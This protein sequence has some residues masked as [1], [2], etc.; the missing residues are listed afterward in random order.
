[1]KFTPHKLL[2]VG[3]ALLLQTTAFAQEYHSNDVTPAG[4]GSGKLTAASA[5]RQVG[6]SQGVGSYN[7]HAVLLSGN[8]V[9]G[10]DLNPP[11]S[12]YSLATC[13]DDLQ[14]GGW[15][16]FA[17][18]QHAVVWSG[19]AASCAD[20]NPSGYNFSYCLGVHA[21]EQVGYAQLQSYFISASHAYSWHGSSASGVDLH[22][23]SAYSFSRAVACH[24]GEE[25]GCVSTIA[26]PE[27]EYSITYYHT[28]SHAMRWAGTAASAVDLHPL[29]FDSSEATCTSG[30]QQGG[31]GYIALGI[32]HLHAL[33]WSGTADTV[34]D[35][36]PN[37]YTESRISAMNATQQV[38]DGW[39][40]APG[41]IGS[42]RHALAWSG[43]ADTVVDLNQ[44]LPA[45][46]THGVATG[47]DAAGNI[48]GYACNAFQAGVTI[49]QG[50]V[51]VVFAPGA[52]PATQIASVTL[53]ASNVEPGATVQATVA[54][55]GPAPAGGVN[56]TFLSTSPTLVATPAPL[57]IPEGD[58]TAAISLQTGGLTLPVPASLKLYATD[59]A[60]S[61]FANL[62]VT[63]VVKLA[64]IAGNPVEGGFSTYGTVTLAIP[65]QA[66][67]AAVSLSSGNTA[68]VAVPATVTLPQGYSS[69]SFTINTAPVSALTSVPI[70]ATFNGTTVAGSVSLNPAPVV[71]LSGLSIP[72][73]VGGQTVVGTVTL[74]NFPRSASGAVITLASGDTGTLQ[75]PATVTVPQGAYSATFIATTTVVPG[76]K[77]VSVKA[78][79]GGGNL[80]TTV[81]VNPIPTV[82]LLSADWDP[83]TLLFKVK[84]DTSYANSIMTFGTD[85][86]SGPIGTMQ[87]ELGIWIGAILM[88]TA[89]TTAT[90][91][92]SN[93]GQ[94]SMPVTIKGLASGGG[95]GGGGS[96]SSTYKLSVSKTGKGTVTTNPAGTSF[97][98]GTVVTLTA[99][100]DAGSPWI[101]WSGSVVSKAQTISVTM[102][103]NL[104]LTANFK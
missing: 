19:T 1:M 103:G 84:A 87:L 62:T 72:A 89:P 75:V 27:G 34:L 3:S 24:D 51:A 81:S 90:V 28:G 13:A 41:A 46:Y 78:T 2:A 59:G 21:G 76:L 42:V 38:G 4:A 66:G 36:H 98:P 55:G 39:V 67:G 50:A 5:G 56:I 69:I 18:A 104:S 22:P 85:A 29:G 49:P 95:G 43:T 74:N 91:W 60:V 99:T 6:G 48:V 97:A 92:N 14:Q 15:A 61:R 79:Y 37:G 71:A 88:A 77:G 33:L 53:D 58:S 30:T 8:A 35:L 57:V 82:T 52:A 9:T 80:G 40:G 102:N 10:V 12:S 7:S 44:Y 11:L 94:A 31:W 54:L 17:G 83:T 73:V 96:T 16:Y 25:V 65:A 64:G 68:L 45:G 63:P 20:L 47:I 23:V 86:A 101:G 93:G 32:S 100:P 26:Y 70:T